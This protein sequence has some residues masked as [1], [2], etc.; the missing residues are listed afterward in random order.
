MTTYTDRLRLALQETGENDTTWGDV[1]NAGVFTLLEHAIAG[2]VSV[3]VA[4]GNVTLSASNGAEDQARYAILNLTGTPPSARD[5]IVPARSK[6]YLVINSTSGG[7]TITVKTASG[8]GVTIPAGVAKFVYCD[9]TNV[10]DVYAAAA[11]ADSATNADNADALGGVAAA[12]WARLNVAQ[13]FTGAQR[14]SRVT[15]SNSGGNV[16]VNAALSN[17]FSLTMAGNWTLANPTNPVN[18]QVIR[19]IIKQ[20]GT[21]NRVITWGS[22]YAFPGGVTPVLS[23][24]ANSID[25]AS[26]E[27]DQ[28]ADLWIG[29]LAKGFA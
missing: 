21:G 28:A 8:T 23:T 27:Y 3:S 14:V 10:E 12:S 24:A 1:L 22:K 16:A 7:Q 13:T 2:M 26:F 15:L 9:A 18:G 19:I 20:D 25:Y 11:S 5:V 4:A 17:T 6:I 29:A